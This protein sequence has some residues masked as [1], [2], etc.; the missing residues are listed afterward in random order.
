[1]SKTHANISIDVKVWENAKKQLRGNISQRI[2]DYLRHTLN[3]MNSDIDGL[4]VQ[5]LHQELDKKR[6]ILSEIVADIHELD[7]KIH[8]INENIEKK[9]SE[10]L[11]KD[12]QEA[13]KMVTCK[14]CQIPKHKERMHKTSADDNLCNGCFLSLDADTLRKYFHKSMKVFIKK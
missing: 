1:M 8:T 4:E 13:L 7:T 9:E 11:E 6:G 5:E 10:Q 3:L 2:E 14:H 12:K